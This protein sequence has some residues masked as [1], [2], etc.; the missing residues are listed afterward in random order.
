MPFVVPGWVLVLPFILVFR[1]VNGWR[2]WLLGAFAVV[3]GPALLT[4]SLGRP[5]KD[6]LLF[7]EMGL[8]VSILSIGS[9]LI[10]LRRFSRGN[11]EETR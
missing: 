1:R 5:S 10:A 6:D 3:L 9:Y 11:I 7:F 8:A 4:V 2:L